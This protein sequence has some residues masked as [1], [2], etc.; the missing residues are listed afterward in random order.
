MSGNPT[1]L[2]PDPGIWGRRPGQPVPSASPGSPGTTP[3]G[4][5]RPPEGYEEYGCYGIQPRN[6]LTDAALCEEA[7]TAGRLVWPFYAND[8]DEMRRLVEAGL[9][10]GV[11]RAQVSC[12][13]RRL[14]RGYPE[15][16]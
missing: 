7:H 13:Q 2:T 16:M 8:E 5:S 10:A 3:K 6:H 11:A 4:G 15:V 12:W 1:L 14:S 9:A